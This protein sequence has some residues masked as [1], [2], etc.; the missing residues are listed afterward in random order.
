MV[1]KSPFDSGSRSILLL[2]PYLYLLIED[3]IEINIDPSDIRIDTYR[4]SGA[5]GQHV[6]KTDSAVRLTH[7]PTGVVV[8]CQ[9]DRSQHKNKDRAMKQLRAKLYELELKKQDEAM[10][11]LEETKADISWGGQ[12]GHTS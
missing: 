1:R 9:S 12:L 8:Q 6:N 10:K 5:G 3:N 11:N 4:A 7:E 2:L